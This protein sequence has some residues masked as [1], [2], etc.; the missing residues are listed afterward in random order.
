MRNLKI[1]SATRVQHE[2]MDTKLI[3]NHMHDKNIFFAN[4]GSSV[5][6]CNNKSGDVKEIYCGGEIV[7]MEFL[8]LNESLCVAT[9]EGEIITIDLSS[10]D[11]HCETVGLVADGIEEM[12]WSPDQELVVFVSK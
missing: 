2:P 8:Q 10:D 12:R 3:V 1:V 6:M 7:S 9:S 11:F 5:K 4:D